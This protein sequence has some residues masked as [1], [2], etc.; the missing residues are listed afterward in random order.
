[1]FEKFLIKPHTRVFCILWKHVAAI[2]HTLNNCHTLHG[3]V[4][5]AQSIFVIG[6]SSNYYCR[7]FLIWSRFSFD[8]F[9]RH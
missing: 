5:R 4:N 2:L 7:L 9:M 1:M 6:A 3:R 8:F